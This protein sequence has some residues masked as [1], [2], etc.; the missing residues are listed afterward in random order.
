MFPKLFQAP[1]VSSGSP[2][3]R[4]SLS[5]DWHRSKRCIFIPI[6]MEIHMAEYKMVRSLWKLPFKPC[7]IPVFLC[8]DRQWKHSIVIYVSSRYL[9]QSAYAIMNFPLSSMSWPVDSPPAHRFDHSNFTSYLQMYR[10]PY[11]AHQ[12]FSQWMRA[13]FL[14]WYPFFYFPIFTS[15]LDIEP[16]YLIQVCTYT[17]SKHS[18]RTKSLWPNYSLIYEYFSIDQRLDFLN[19]TQLSKQHMNLSLFALRFMLHWPC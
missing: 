1:R 13:T 16:S 7:T 18:Q 8:T 9:C 5:V 2:L 6:L 14:K 19:H 11:C 15:C 17:R 4:L 10:C 12:I 3:D